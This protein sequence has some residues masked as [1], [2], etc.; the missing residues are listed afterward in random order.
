MNLLSTWFTAMLKVGSALQAIPSTTELNVRG[1]GGGLITVYG[2]IGI[3]IQ[4]QDERQDS[5]NTFLDQRF[6][7]SASLK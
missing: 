4:I 1:C 6:K 5:K 3:G 7:F 2:M